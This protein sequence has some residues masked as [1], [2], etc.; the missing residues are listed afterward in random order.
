MVFQ[1]LNNDKATPRLLLSIFI[2]STSLLG[3]QKFD[4]GTYMSRTMFKNPYANIPAQCYIETSFGTQNACLFCHSNGLANITL[5]NNNPQAGASLVTGNLQLDYAFGPVNDFTVSPNIN[6]WENTLYPHKLNE[7]LKKLKIDSS[8]WDMDKYVKENNWQVAFDKIGTKGFKF[9]PD[10]NP[11]FLPARSDGFVYDKSGNNTLWRSINF[12]PYGI[13]IPLT[14]S[15]SGIYIRLPKIFAQNNSGQIDIEVYKQNLQLLE[16][17][18]KDNLT[19]N[20]PK[21]YFG[22]ASNIDV[23]R[24]SYPINTQFAHPLHYVDMDKNG[25]RATRVKEI[26]YSY[27]YRDFTSGELAMKEEDGK[28]Y[29][30]Q[31]EGWIDNGAGWYL[32]GFIEDKKGDLRA[33]NGE[34]LMQCV[35]CHSD[36]YG[37]EPSFFT[38]GT[39]NT[40][41]NTWAFP[42][43]LTGQIGWGEMDYLRHQVDKD[44]KSHSKVNEKI[45]KH[46]KIGEF[47]LFLDYVVGANLYGLM[48]KHIETFLT[49]E[50]KK[51][52]GYSNSWVQVDLTS[53]KTLK[54][55]QQKRQKL[56]REFTAKGRYL[57]D[58]GTI[59]SVFLY[60]TKQSA[61]NGA[62]NYRKVV[63]TQSYTLGKDV[64]DKTPFTYLYYRDKATSFK[65]ANG[66]KYK[67]GNVIKSRQYIKDETILKGVG[68]TK[69]LIDEKLE[70]KDGGTYFENYIPI[71]E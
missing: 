64:F 62:K 44:G 60:P 14:G 51:E 27:K 31:S 18:I 52:N 35:G 63:A 58:D 66:K 67:I 23:K 65:A 43:K 42:R 22:K 59:K 11:S 20:S 5:G 48:D 25:T 12:F 17:A 38:S 37:F 4:D 47:R 15:V 26:R 56:L 50:I 32:A 69:T 53:P 39:S 6:P 41:D 2:L 13:F 33:Q 70:F 9:F 28:I 54:L 36:R 29:L 16:D 8:K 7:K 40:I 21:H 57:N 71:L 61:L 68:D 55:S 1:L 49:N 30:N 24:G 46:A 45:N 34:E 19:Q 10:L 3:S